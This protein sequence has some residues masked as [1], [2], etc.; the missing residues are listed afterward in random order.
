MTVNARVVIVREVT[1]AK[2]ENVVVVP[3]TAK[4]VIARMAS[5]VRA[6][7]EDSNLTKARKERD[8]VADVILTRVKRAKDAKVVDLIP[9]ERSLLVILQS[10]NLA[11]LPNDLFLEL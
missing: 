9:M 4:T 3:I 11:Q 7:E 8:L 1:A 10:L 5:A 6:K 2:V